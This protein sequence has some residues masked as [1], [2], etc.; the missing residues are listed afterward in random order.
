MDKESVKV[1]TGYYG[2]CPY[3][4][5][6]IANLKEYCDALEYNLVTVFED[7]PPLQD[8]LFWCKQYLI[9]KELVDCDYLL[10][11]DADCLI[12][13]MTFQVD[14]FIL[15]RDSV[16]MTHEEDGWQAGVM[17]F[18]NDAAAHRFLDDWWWR[19]NQDT[20]DN[21]EL[22]KMLKHI[23]PSYYRIHKFD[24]TFVGK[25]VHFEFKKSW[26]THCPGCEP[27][28]KKDVM[29]Y[30]NTQVYTHE[31]H[32]LIN[33]LVYSTK[34]THRDLLLNAHYHCV[35]FAPQEYHDL[36][37][38]I[39]YYAAGMATDVGG[40]LIYYGADYPERLLRGKIANKVDF[41]NDLEPYLFT[42]IIICGNITNASLHRYL[43]ILKLKG[44]IL[45]YKNTSDIVLD[46][47]KY[48]IK[49]ISD[50]KVIYYYNNIDGKVVP[51]E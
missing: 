6:V 24:T 1:V 23:D 45:L 44:R 10:W 32:L 38:A 37:N 33:R 25:H 15:R 17:L 51:I 39:L 12:T 41:W 18:R 13:N 48:H 31:D 30:L 3:R 5:I 21:D 4:D 47:T 28:E 2:H 50:Y 8:N 7:T 42:L 14:D 46:P 36:N 20:G 49:E 16:V 19:R 11:V 26:I 43:D 34:L 9:R 22:E 40:R 35:L 27:E 29:A